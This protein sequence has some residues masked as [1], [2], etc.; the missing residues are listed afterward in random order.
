M[1]DVP[2]LILELKELSNEITTRTKELQKLKNRKK[3]IEETLCKFFEE[4]KQ[5]GIKYKGV[6]VIAEDTKSRARKKKLEKQEDCVGI[7]RNCGL[8]NAE[9]V[10][11]EILE[12][13]KGEE[14]SK[15][16]IKIQSLKP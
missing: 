16:K 5:P 12:K 14:I 4:K 6:A 2:G 1:S 3:S 9:K 15:K 7:L 8:N 10:Y 13:M 11:K